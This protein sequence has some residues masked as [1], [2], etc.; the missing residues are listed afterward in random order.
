[1]IASLFD[2]SF[3]ESIS[4]MTVPILLAALGGAICQRAGVFNIALE[5]FIIIGAFMAV[6]GSYFFGSASVGL[7]CAMAGGVFMALLF[8]EFH[9]RRAGDPIIVSI[10]LNLIGFGLSTYL[11]RA[12]L[13]V[14]GVFQH[15]GIKKISNIHIPLIES[16]PYVGKLLSGQSL[17]FYFSIIAVLFCHAFYAKHRLGLWMRAAGENASGLTSLGVSPKRM[18]FFALTVCGVL[19][20]LAGAQLS[21][22]NVGLFVENMSAGR[23]WIAVVAVLVSGG[24]PLPLLGLVFLFG[25]VDSMSLRVQGFGW[26]Q[27]F[28]EILPYLASLLALIIVSY[29]RLRK[30]WATKGIKIT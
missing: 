6:L 22:S 17:L 3:A 1:M 23:G 15:D 4:R 20:G 27:Q 10:A 8:A 9:L 29:K 16:L 12:I 21:I 13:G 7:F 28:T 25:G 11:L 24:R 26:P 2:P 18:Q 5:G 19:C 14:S 30:D